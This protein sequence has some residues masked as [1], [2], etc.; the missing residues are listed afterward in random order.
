MACWA[1]GTYSVRCGV[2]LFQQES[3]GSLGDGNNRNDWRLLL[4]LSW[5]VGFR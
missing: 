4:L 3:G 1:A 2:N 5:W